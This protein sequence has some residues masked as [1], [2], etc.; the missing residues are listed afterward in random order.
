MWSFGSRMMG[1]GVPDSLAQG[2]LRTVYYRRAG[3]GGTGLGL[4]IVRTVAVSTTP[5]SKSPP[6]S[7]WAAAASR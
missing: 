2:Y 6:A 4:A 3:E 5:G 7:A 1:E